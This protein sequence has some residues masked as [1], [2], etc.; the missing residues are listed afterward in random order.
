[1][2]GTVILQEGT[3]YGS[4]NNSQGGTLYGSIK[5]SDILSGLISVQIGYELYAGPYDV[6]PNFNE[7]KLFT[8]S[9]AMARNVIVESIPYSEVSNPDGG[10]TINIGG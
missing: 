3:L 2:D 4:I 8:A 6:I 1:M 7:Q 10:I 5:T 9:K